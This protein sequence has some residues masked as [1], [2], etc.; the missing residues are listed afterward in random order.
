MTVRHLKTARSAADRADDD[1]KVRAIVEA[2]LKDIDDRGDA[3]VR[4]MSEKFD[5]YSPPSYRLSLPEIEALM[6][7]VPDR[8]MSDL[9]FAQ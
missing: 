5:S 9:K 1:T 3:A 6:A 2:G 8:D 4:A 7:R